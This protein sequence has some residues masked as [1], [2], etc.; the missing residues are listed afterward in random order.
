MISV[1]ITATGSQA[2]WD[3]IVCNFKPDKIYVYGDPT[4]LS[5]S[6]LSQATPLQKPEDLPYNHSLI[7][8]APTNGT[9]IQGDES[10]ETFTHPENAI[11][12]FGSDANHIEAEVFSA[13]TPDHVVFIPTDTND[14]MYAAA[15]YGVV[16]WDRKVKSLWPS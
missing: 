8:L 13:R 12:W 4:A 3:F 5:S 9:N 2:H 16:M 1:V 7:V 15:A 6:V 11:Y 10:L 14:Q